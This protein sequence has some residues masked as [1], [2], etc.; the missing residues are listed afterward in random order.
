MGEMIKMVVVLTILSIVSGGGLAKLKDFTEPKIDNN[1]MNLVKGPAIRA[2]LSE[3][4]NDPVADR[5]KIMD[6]ETER[7]VFIGVFNGKANTVIME[8]EA[9]GYADKIGLVVGINMDEQTL[10]G[11]AVTRV[12]L[13][14]GIVMLCRPASASPTSAPARP[15]LPRA[16]RVLSAQAVPAQRNRMYPKTIVSATRH[17]VMVRATGPRRIA[18]PAA[19]MSVSIRASRRRSAITDEAALPKEMLRYRFTER[20]FEKSPSLPGVHAARAEAIV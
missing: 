4:E 7:N 9:S 13:P 20:A 11:I 8:A 18:P 5:F 15:T 12:L 2:M 1:V 10:A 6:G 19:A 17:Q 14:E 16:A 3:A